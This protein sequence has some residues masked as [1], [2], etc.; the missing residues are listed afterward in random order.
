MCSAKGGAVPCVLA[1]G[2][3]ALPYWQKKID[4]SGLTGQV[5]LLGH[6]GDVKELLAAADIL[7]SPTHFDSYGLGVHEA[8]CRGIPAI[9]TATAGIA[10]RFPLEMRDLLL[11]DP[12]DGAELAKRIETWRLRA[13][14][15]AAATSKFGAALRSWTWDDMAARMIECIESARTLTASATLECA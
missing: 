8:V 3:G 6:I 9:V 1:A 11:C 14:E 5:R 13:N 2:S 7:V 15:F 10:D 4:Q 12:K